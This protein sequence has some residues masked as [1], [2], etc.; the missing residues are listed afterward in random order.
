MGLPRDE[1]S[2]KARRGRL[3]RLALDE[4]EP[5]TLLATL[6]VPTVSST[7]V[8][9]STPFGPTSYDATTSNNPP[10]TTPNSV[11][12]GNNSSP[13]IVINP[14][15]PQQMAAVWETDLTTPG[16]WAVGRRGR[17]LLDQRRDDLE[18]VHARR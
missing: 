9:L 6:P 16:Q 11:A 7:Y 10:A 2:Q 13:T 5:R 14:A 3:R 18:G 12:G 17:A 15:N 8:N 1:S 4:L